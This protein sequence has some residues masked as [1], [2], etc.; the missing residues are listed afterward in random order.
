[1]AENRKTKGNEESD[2]KISR[3]IKLKAFENDSSSESEEEI[4]EYFFDREKI[5]KRFLSAWNN[6]KYGKYS[7][8]QYKRGYLRATLCSQAKFIPKQQYFVDPIFKF[9]F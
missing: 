9:V 7:L 6:V 8:H 4:E 2:S 5:K 1:M 3:I